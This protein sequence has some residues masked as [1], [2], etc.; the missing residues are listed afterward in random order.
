MNYCLFRDILYETVIT[1]KWLVIKCVSNIILS[2]SKTYQSEKLIIRLGN[3]IFKNTHSD[4]DSYESYVKNINPSLKLFNDLFGSDEWCNGKK[5]L[6]LG[7]GLGLWS[8]LL[9]K[10]A[11]ADVIALDLG[12]SQCKFAKKYWHNNN[13]LLVNGAAEN[14]PFKVSSI[15][16][17]FS[18]TVFEHILNVQSALK[19]V[20]Y[21]LKPDGIFVLN[22]HFINHY[23]GHHLNLYVN[24]PWATW[25]VSE[26]S[27]CKYFSERLKT[28]QENGKILYYPKGSIVKMLKEKN[29]IQ[30]NKLNYKQFE[31][32]ITNC[33]FEIEKRNTSG[34]LLKLLPFLKSVFWFDT[35]LTGTVNYILRKAMCH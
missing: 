12:F 11:N 3:I 30:L 25:V 19:N 31:V 23:M 20:Y 8:D 14:L 15:E 26:E 33:G 1:L 29:I 16:T 34:A 28:D 9:V 7:S 17:V 21:I 22:F 6:D 13:V 32:M 35:F 4:L 18:H 5:I 10:H 27:L 2:I 24:M